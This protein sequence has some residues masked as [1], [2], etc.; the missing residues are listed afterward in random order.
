MVSLAGGLQMCQAEFY[1]LF[2]M[3]NGNV[4]LRALITFPLG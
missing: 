3:D 1:R 2:L 4:D